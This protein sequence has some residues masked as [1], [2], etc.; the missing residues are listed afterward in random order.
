M[1]FIPDFSV[2]GLTLKRFCAIFFVAVGS[3]LTPLLDMGV[4]CASSGSKEAAGVRASPALAG[5][6]F[7]ALRVTDFA[8]SNIEP[9]T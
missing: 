8:S 9:V 5:G 7:R 6:F 4:G 3:N 2:F 1:I